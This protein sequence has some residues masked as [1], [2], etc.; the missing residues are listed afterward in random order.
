MAEKDWPEFDIFIFIL[1][2]N[3][4]FH[5]PEFAA[6]LDL[7]TRVLICCLDYISICIF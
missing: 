4:C 7:F 3:D 5:E 2:V 6:V 1:F